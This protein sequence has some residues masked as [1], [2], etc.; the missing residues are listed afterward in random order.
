MTKRAA[1]SPI[2]ITQVETPQVDHR[3]KLEEVVDQLAK[4][5][6]GAP[7]KGA[8]G[9]GEAGETRD[10]IARIKELSVQLAQE[11]RGLEQ[12]SAAPD[13]PRRILRK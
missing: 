3:I 13:A 9:L 1:K 6:R 10:R 11:L 5:A 4:K 8:R 7:Q 2:E 12:S